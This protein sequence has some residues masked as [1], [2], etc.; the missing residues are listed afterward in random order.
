MSSQ[1]E[2]IVEIWK[3]AVRLSKEGNSLW[4]TVKER[5]NQ[6]NYGYVRKLPQSKTFLVKLQI[7]MRGRKEVP[8]CMVR[9]VFINNKI[10]ELQNKFCR[11]LA[12][13]NTSFKYSDL[14]IK[15]CKPEEVKDKPDDHSLVFGKTFS[16][17]MFEVEWT[18]K[19]G[20]GKPIISPL[21]DLVLHPAAKVLHY[22]QELFEGMKAF[23]SRN[24]QAYLFRPD[25]NMKRMLLTAER[26][27]LPKFDGDELLK[28]MK[29][30]IA[31]DQHWIPEKEGCALYIRPT[32]IESIHLWGGQ[33]K[34]VS[35]LA[36]PNHVR[37]WPGGV[38]SRKMGCNYAPTIRI[39]Q[40]A[41]MQNLQQ[42]L[43]L[44]GENHQLAEV[45]TMNIF[46][47]L[48]NSTGDLELVTP[49]L[50]G[51]ILPGIIRQSLLD[52]ANE[53]NEFKV[54]ERHITMKEVIQAN[55]E[56]RLLEIFG[57]GTA[58]VVCPVG[59]ISY[60]NETISVPTLKS[61]TAL[62]RRFSNVLLDIQYGKV[63]SKW[64]VP[65]DKL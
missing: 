10:H 63:P 24:G 13:V 12:S 17:H 43:W 53:W 64:A 4:V 37:A 9:K 16:D 47:L 31:I 40:M 50:D 41:E 23:K 5:K 11:N 28:C 59:S 44:F 27:S 6:S 55:S 19:H 3:I 32:F 36:D 54:S 60:L 1:S 57:S 7:N 30:L 26:T 15:T 52:L 65:I 35:L 14:V 33:E 62:Y 58:C 22:A 2:T 48:S 42:V 39:Q 29:K 34:A 20:W 25:L 38:G 46:V 21:H 8:H 45:G 18:E 51:T 56:G 49:P 61:E